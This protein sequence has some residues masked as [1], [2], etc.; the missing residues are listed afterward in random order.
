ML[1]DLTVQ[2]CCDRTKQKHQ[3]GLFKYRVFFPGWTQLDM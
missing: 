2:E 3:L 1:R